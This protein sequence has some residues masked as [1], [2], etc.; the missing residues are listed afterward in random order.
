MQPENNNQKKRGN[1][2][3]IDLISKIRVNL[4]Y[5]LGSEDHKKDAFVELVITPTYSSALVL[6][7]N[8]Y[9]L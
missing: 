8:C 9:K 6:G 7:A 4:P 5:L 1:F 2:F 3:I